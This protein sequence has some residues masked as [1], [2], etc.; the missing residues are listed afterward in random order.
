MKTHFFS[1]P[2]DQPCRGVRLTGGVWEDF[3]YL[4]MDPQDLQ[5]FPDA[6]TFF[7]AGVDLSL[8]HLRQL[9]IRAGDIEV[10]PGPVRRSKRLQV[11]GSISSPAN[12]ET[13]Q[14]MKRHMKHTKF[15][16]TQLIKA[17]NRFWCLRSDSDDEQEHSNNSPTVE[18][19]NTANTSN[20]NENEQRDLENANAEITNEDSR[21][22]KRNKR[23][24]NRLKRE[25]EKK[26][27][28]LTA[29]CWNAGGL[30]NKKDSFEK[31][32]TD[33]KVDIILIQELQGGTKTAPKITGFNNPVVTRR[34]RG[35]R[36]SDSNPRGGNTAIY[37]RRGLR[38]E[39]IKERPF[40]T[41]DVTTEWNGIEIF[42]TD[43][44][45]IVMHN[46][47][48]PPIRQTEQDERTDLFSTALWPTGKNIIYA[49][50]IN[51]HHP[52]WEE[53]CCS[54]DSIGEA[55]AD[56]CVE[57]RFI[58]LNDGRPTRRAPNSEGTAP[59]VILCHS[60]L[61]RRMSW[62]TAEDDFGSDH[63]PM[64]L[65]IK[66]DGSQPS[67]FPRETYC[68]KKANW[69]QFTEIT[70]EKFANIDRELN[71]HQLAKEF[72]AHVIYAADKTIPKG[73]RRTPRPW[74]EGQDELKAL[75]KD[76]V[77]K[78]KKAHLGV[79]EKEEWYEARRK[80]AEEI[81]KTRSKEWKAFCA[82]LSYR[83][84]PSKVARIFNSLDE[85][86]GDTG[87]DQVIRNKGKILKSNVEKATAFNNHYA[88]VSRLSFRKKDKK[89][90]RIV[91]AKLK[92]KVTDTEGINSPF[93]KTDLVKLIQEAKTGRATGD[94]RISNEMMKN[95]GP[96]GIDILLKLIN[97]SWSQ[98]VVPN[99]WRRAKIIPLHKKGKSH[100]EILSYRP[101]ALTSHVAKIAER[102]I[103]DRLY[104]WAE[105][106]QL[107]P[108]EQFGF[109]K[110]KSTEDCIARIIQTVQDGW[111]KTVNRSKTVKEG[112]QDKAARSVILAFDF[113]KAY[114]KVWKTGL[115][116]KLIKQGVPLKL[117]KWIDCF[118]NRRVAKV[119]VNN[120]S[121]GWKKYKDG[122][123][124]G[125][126][127]SPLLFVLFLA[128]LPNDLNSE[129][130]SCNLY[131]DDTSVIAQGNTLNE[132]LR[133]AQQAADN[134]MK[135]AWQWKMR[136]ATEKTQML[137]CTQSSVEAQ[138][139]IKAEKGEA[140]QAFI[141]M[142]RAKI[143]P[144]ECI[145]ILGVKLDRL[146]H[147]G[148]QCEFV[149]KKARR[150]VNQLARISARTWGSDETT[151]H[152][153]VT[154]FVD[155]TVRYACGG[156]M[157]AASKSHL[158]KIE[159]ERRRAARI[160]TNCVR[161]TPIDALM[162]E[163][164]LQ[165]LEDIAVSTGAALYEKAKRLPEGEPLRKL[166]EHQPTRTLKTVKGWRKAGE[167]I[168]AECKLD[169]LPRD[170]IPQPTLNYCN[171]QINFS[172]ID[173]ISKSEPEDTLRTK[174][175][176]W[177]EKQE[178]CEYTIWT[179][180]SAQE[181]QFDGGAGIVI[182]EGE[183]IVQQLHFP[184]GRFCSSTDAELKAIL[185][186]LQVLF[187]QHQG[188]GKSVR[189]C[190]DSQAAIAII[191]RGP[192]MQSSRVSADIWTY[193]EKTRRT[194]FQWVPA[195]CGLLNNEIADDLAKQGSKTIQTEESITL[196][197]ARNQIRLN[198]RNKRNSNLRKDWHY[199]IF[200]S[201]KPEPPSCDGE[202]NAVVH[203]LR[204]GHCSLLNQYRHRIGKRPIGGGC[205][206]C[207]DESCP[208]SM[209]DICGCEADTVEHV[210]M[211]CPGTDK[212][213]REESIRATSDWGNV[214]KMRRMAKFLLGRPGRPPRR[215]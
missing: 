166:A 215:Q 172:F 34:T 11:C 39:Q 103:K 12:P 75:I 20:S 93:L 45:S 138:E 35:R 113:A 3:P 52:L 164:D 40:V 177:L 134:F 157:A 95:L 160:Q 106:H 204:T 162:R 131:A 123:P 83:T 33:E 137:I 48:R 19:E 192:H 5:E 9:L 89:I 205:Q 4:Q 82:E 58:P 163:A 63:T 60:D 88:E 43:E 84:D 186:G 196:K 120:E 37:T 64:V 73:A 194:D 110:G 55:V 209:C 49:G 29:V 111:E 153:L 96:S 114:D 80:C 152:S 197:T 167:A 183:V 26:S 85:N 142:N 30:H 66:V 130:V 176:E 51:A 119:V 38:Y 158:E 124:Q 70:E 161:S 126:V 23:R 72:E 53:T 16:K 56:W 213:R 21:K 87:S 206:A 17:T 101:I 151:K 154:A 129:R 90:K 149:A 189:I 193:I 46:I 115:A 127:L 208:A 79:L 135:W 57:N 169:Q 171:A 36:A 133:N 207:R 132:A 212:I 211:R 190:L 118:I 143:L 179:D 146:L 136:V 68:Y 104:T 121:S 140:T 18:N 112:L 156:W 47:Y 170:E 77:E 184:A 185:Y 210:L 15:S 180:G 65:K 159:V 145:T 7:P 74:I 200:G 31:W 67:I 125:S 150:R 97:I 2:V 25:K 76:R 117:I 24:R 13:K 181:G 71:V 22:S 214:G 99:A 91:K 105:S 81:M 203:Q 148:K 175:A 28:T 59:D 195:H 86:I 14:S 100:G 178:K 141:W 165:P 69:E 102:L 199:A 173:N 1:N 109:R 92:E 42:T 62:D 78:K 155:S 188:Q 44:R 187:E 6:V 182:L 27:S 8:A 41:E 168:S 191:R 10:N 50:D 201:K 108:P 198:V 144:S 61:E 122:L 98:S 128:D 54:P 94:D 116:H 174:A 107:I 32:V 139:A 202:L 147:M